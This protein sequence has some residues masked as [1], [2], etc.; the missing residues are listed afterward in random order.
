MKRWPR[1]RQIVIVASLSAVSM[2]VA[3]GSWSAPAEQTGPR[4]VDCRI[5][6]RHEYKVGFWTPIWVSVRGS[7]P[8]KTR[9]EV[10]VTDS[11]G[12]PT[13]LAT[14]LRSAADSPGQLATTLLY[15]KIGRMGSPVD[16]RLLADGKVVDQL[17]LTP[18]LEAGQG[19][20][21]P[22]LPATSE[23]LVTFGRARI[24]LSQALPNRDASSGDLARRV[25]HLNQ[26][27][28][29][30]AKWYGY[31][32]VDMLVL[33]A[34]DV[35]LF[36]GLA[37][38]EA[39][40]QA[41]KKWV[42]LGGRLV[43]LC[44][45]HAPELIAPSGPFAS[46]AP[47]RFVDLVRLPQAG[48]LEQF[49]GSDVP[50]LTR[51]SDRELIVA[52]LA[53][54][55]GQI[56]AYEGRQ[57]SDLPLV[58][59]A[60][61]GLGEIVFGGVDLDEPPL[62]EWRG[63]TSMLRALVQLGMP[64]LEGAATPSPTLVTSGYN[65]LAGALRQRLGRSFPSISTIAF[66]VVALL[67][68]GYLL[69]LGPLDY[70][71]VHRVLGRPILAWVTFP[72]IV[73]ATSGGAYWLAES[74]RGDRHVNQLE[75]VDVDAIAGQARGT[76]WGTLYSPRSQ[77][78]DLALSVRL[79]DGQTTDEAEVLLSDLGLPGSGVGGTQ[80]AGGDWETWDVDYQTTAGGSALVGVPIQV[81]ATKSLIARWQA[82]VGTLVESELTADPDGVLAGSI[83]NR[84]EMAWNDALLLYGGWAYRLG[85]VA[86]GAQVNV[87]RDLDPV[88]ARTLLARRARGPDGGTSSAAGREVFEPQRASLE[89]LLEVMMFYEA[90]GG[91]GF[92]GLPNRYE[93]YCDLS[94]LL[95]LGRA[96]L[97]VRSPR[98]GSELVDRAQAPLANPEDP[99][100]VMY[101]FVLPVNG[102]VETD[103]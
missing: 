15:A 81:A 77:C 62:A 56:E 73:V 25:V 68:V 23:L 19:R 12:V 94:D 5:G 14:D 102:A 84:S 65:D 101:R 83:A 20:I 17:T 44:G 30:P 78:F 63:K 48:A 57:P 95:D 10:T 42:E 11:D 70:L 88:R 27:D 24:G 9:V 47:G 86:V 22:G 87:G 58:I 91:Y 60:P 39:R 67:A 79:P 71:F 29:L 89:Q 93:G 76:Y 64:P 54:V 16:V 82:A 92:A 41:L 33:S 6:F 32:A 26:V 85:R 4:I 37:A 51:L 31:E 7:I 8:A 55:T 53:D 98:P 36:Q 66:S 97:V 1:M 46:L 103:D 43:L 40:L 74:N 75:L 90:V 49:A 35:S 45:R 38:D 99:R 59:R 34:T 72:L 52:Q 100:L 18:G 2:L 21:L 50:I 96:I 69:V 28:E 13:S 80:A 3:S 61:H